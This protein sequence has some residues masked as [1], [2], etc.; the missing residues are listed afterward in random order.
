MAIGAKCFQHQSGVASTRCL[1]P[2]LRVIRG[3]C[4]ASLFEIVILMKGHVGGGPGSGSF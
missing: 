1:T 3:N 2:F 4:G